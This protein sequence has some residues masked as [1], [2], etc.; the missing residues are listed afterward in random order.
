MT[1]ANK[2]S[3]SKV[4]AQ[5]TFTGRSAV[6]FSQIGVGSSAHTAPIRNLHNWGCSLWEIF[7]CDRPAGVPKSPAPCSPDVFAFSLVTP[8]LSLWSRRLVRGTLGRELFPWPTSH[9]RR[10]W[11]RQL[12]VTLLRSFAARFKILRSPGVRSFGFRQ[13]H[14]A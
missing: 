10:E 11:R 14:S 9:H 7:R 1:C 5:A 2:E 8:V 12:V 4:P 13:A 6:Q 3:T